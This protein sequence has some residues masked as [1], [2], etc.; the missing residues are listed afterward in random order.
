VEKAFW[1]SSRKD[2]RRTGL[3]LLLREVFPILEWRNAVEVQYCRL[4]VERAVSTNDIVFVLKMRILS[5]LG[6]LGTTIVR[7]RFLVD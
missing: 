1:R 6:S 3:I 4:E 2:A 7:I 5:R